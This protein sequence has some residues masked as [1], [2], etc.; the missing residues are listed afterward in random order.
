MMTGLIALLAVA[1]WASMARLLGP[2]VVAQTGVAPAQFQ[3]ISAGMG[4]AFLGGVL[5]LTGAIGNA[6]RPAMAGAALAALGVAAL[7]ILGLLS[8]K[9]LR[10]P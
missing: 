1:Y 2:G 3:R 5:L 9:A 8:L 4:V 10:R 7:I 6:P